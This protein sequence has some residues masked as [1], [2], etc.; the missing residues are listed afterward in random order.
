MSKIPVLT[1]VRIIPRDSNFLN[2]KL[3]SRG[4]IFFDQTTKTLRL[5]DGE[6]VGGFSLAKTDLTNVSNL[7]FFEKGIASGLG[8]GSGGGGTTVSV[9]ATVPSPAQQGNLWLNTNNGSLYVFVSDG[10]SSQWIQPATPVPNVD[11]TGY[12]TED[13]V[14]TAISEIDLSLYAT[15]AQVSEALSSIPRF[16]LN[17]AAD[18]ST[19]RPVLPGNTIKFIGSG[20]VTTASDAD[21][22]ITITGVTDTGDITFSNTAINTSDSSSV[23]FIPSVVFNS[24][25]VVENE[26][27]ANLA[28]FSGKITATSFE[29][30]STSVPEIFSETNLFLSAGNTISLLADKVIAYG[31]G[32]TTENLGEK[33]GAT[34]TV[35]HDF[36][37]TSVWVH[38][39]LAANFTVNFINV[40]TENNR[41]FTAALILIQ[42]ATAR[43]PIAAQIEGS[44]VTINWLNASGVPSGTNNQIDIVSFSL[45]RRNSSWTIIASLATYG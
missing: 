36:Q 15:G 30:N 31:I 20:S 16:E 19:V 12:A 10:D 44:S 3:G 29:N 45:L 28:S 4:E 27:I 25:V 6:E 17:L 33:T 11:L 7:T 43:V 18:D 8:T 13:Y 40:P 41:V 22:N 9:S 26:L 35:D 23:I 21:G 38:T 2:R 14:D 39:S 32:P 42:G 5:F 34:G 24:D 1:A 37:T